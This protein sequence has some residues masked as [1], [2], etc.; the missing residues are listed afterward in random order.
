M[1]RTFVLATALA[2]SSVAANA[3]TVILDTLNK[4]GQ[5]AN[6][7][8]N[9]LGISLFNLVSSSSNTEPFGQSFVLGDA[10]ENLMI[11]TFISSLTF[12]QP[13]SVNISA[14]LVTG[15][16]SAGATLDTIGFSA[17]GVTRNDA[18]LAMFDF[19]G[20]GVLDAGAYTVVFNGDGAIGGGDI[21]FDANGVRTGTVTP[22]T[23]AFDAN[24]LFDFG[25]NPAQEFGIRVSGDIVAPVPLPAGLPLLLA[26][27][28]GLSLLRR[29]RTS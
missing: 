12:P 5:P 28:G 2:I 7:S 20:L 16:G 9:P 15:A 22:G 11:E 25:S 14:T 6:L 1:L 23:Q 13:T 27:L 18:I 17:S 10:T 19:S 24:S 21:F 3:S 8:T 4:N 29:K 26:G